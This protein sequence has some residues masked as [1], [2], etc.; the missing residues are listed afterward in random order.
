MH[1]LLKRQLLKQFG[2]LESVPAEL[3]R[4]LASVSDA[5]QSSDEDRDLHVRSLEITSNELMEK[6]RRLREESEDVRQIV[7][8]IPEGLAVARAGK[9]LVVNNRFAAF[10][11]YTIEEV[12]GMNAFD[13]ALPADY[14]LLLKRIRDA[15]TTDTSS[16]VDIRFQSRTGKT[17]LLEFSPAQRIRFEG[18]PAYLLGVRDVTARK[19]EEEMALL[20]GRMAA[21]GTLTAGIGHEINNPLS[22][23]I[24]N[25]AFVVR[26]LRTTDPEIADSLRDAQEGAERVRRIVSDLKSFSRRG[27]ERNGPVCLRKAV[28]GAVKITGNEI[29]AR[30]QL[31]LSLNAVRLA[32]GN[33]ARLGQ[34]LVNLLVNAAHATPEGAVLENEIRVTTRDIEDRVVIE[35]SD[36]GS[37]MSEEIRARIFD[38]FFT[39]KPVGLGTGLGLSICHGIVAAMGGRIDVES[40]LGAGS[41]FRVTLPA[42]T[43]RADV[44][45]TPDALASRTARI[46]VI[47][48]EPLMGPSISRALAGHRVT[49]TGSGREAVAQLRSGAEYELI[50]CD[51]MMPDMTGMDV[52]EELS[53]DERART[54]F[55]T[56][57]AFTPRARAFVEHSQSEILEKP[58]TP[59]TLA[60]RV[61]MALAM[62]S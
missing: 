20:A 1:K 37:G 52:F 60:A 5:Y 17:V 44:V 41:T 12:Q 8:A 54:I 43:E 23:V 30:A 24:A 33:E 57:G 34:V 21:V 9:F 51:L 36:T 2:S 18:A 47:D 48:D 42:T 46:L 14:P 25:L 53:A 38:P 11:E 7:A 39:T 29:R 58:F 50:L 55:M 59:E 61:A 15:A 10:L 22:Y 45:P 4:F 31:V 62:T 3:A 26:E 19:Q 40:A 13:L 6:N 56:G 35:V 49:W 28:E 32:K 16:R 27:D